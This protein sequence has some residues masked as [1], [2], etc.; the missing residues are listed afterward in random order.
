LQTRRAADTPPPVAL[1]AVVSPST[2]VAGGFS[3]FVDVDVTVADDGLAPIQQYTVTFYDANG[4][5]IG[6]GDGGIGQPPPGGVLHLLA[7]V[8]LIPGTY[9]AGFTLYDAAGNFS[10]YGYPNNHGQPGPGGTLILPILP[11]GG[12]CQPVSIAVT[13]SVAADVPGAVSAGT[14]RSRL[15]P[16]TVVPCPW[17]AIAAA[18]AL[19][20]ARPGTVP[21]A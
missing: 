9:T 21:A 12:G 7:S 20:P 11:A 14:T 13:V 5:P 16:S 1:T 2:V 3:A 15:A 4:V 10:Q 18:S 19:P 6:G 8:S 17:F